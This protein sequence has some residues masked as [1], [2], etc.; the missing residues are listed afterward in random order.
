M[1]A[2]KERFEKRGIKLAGIS[3]DNVGILK[4]FSERRKIEFPLLSDPESKII[5]MYDVLNAKPWGPTRE[6]RGPD[7]SIS[8]PRV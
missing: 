1:Q 3:Y 7:I 5:K 8:I 6:W 2:A 4:Y